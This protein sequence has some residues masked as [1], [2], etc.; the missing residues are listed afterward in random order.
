MAELGWWC[1]VTVSL[2]KY[3]PNIGLFLINLHDCSR[4]SC[5]YRTLD[6]KS[7]YMRCMQPALLYTLDH[8]LINYLL[9]C[10]FCGSTCHIV[11]CIEKMTRKNAYMFGTGMLKTIMLG[12]VVHACNLSPL[13]R[14][15]QEKPRVQ[16]QLLVCSE[17]EAD[18]GDI[19]PCLNQTQMEQNW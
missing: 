6:T 12:V 18:L 1:S 11:L 13:L 19:R 2:H 4:V 7:L 17:F 15:R 5:R 3:K 10:Q 16:G 14:W 9:Q 8:L